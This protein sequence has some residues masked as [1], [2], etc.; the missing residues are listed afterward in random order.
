MNTKT[1]Y[2]TYILY[3]QQTLQLRI[4]YNIHTQRKLNYNHLYKRHLYTV[5]EKAR[6]LTMSSESLFHH[7]AA[8][9]RNECCVLVSLQ[10]R[11]LANLSE[12]LVE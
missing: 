8:A 7:V 3:I 5:R 1:I 9:C 10:Q 12:D 11:I 6:D 2:N 4:I